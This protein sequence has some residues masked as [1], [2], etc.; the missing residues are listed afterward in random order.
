[1][2]WGSY[3]SRAGKGPLASQVYQIGELQVKQETLS[4][5][6]RSVTT[7]EDT[8]VDCWLPLTHMCVPIHTLAL[9]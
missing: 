9:T 3:N 5:K 2:W 8:K 7:E 1:M 4:Q 6:A